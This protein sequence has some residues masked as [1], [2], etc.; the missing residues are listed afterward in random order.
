MTTTTPRPLAG[1]HRLREARTTANLALRGLTARSGVSATTLSAIE[2]WGYLPAP[3]TR[4][5][6]AAALGISISE[7]WPEMEA[8]G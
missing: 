6:I 7:L 3:E 2:R 1:N 5:R 4:S 8:T